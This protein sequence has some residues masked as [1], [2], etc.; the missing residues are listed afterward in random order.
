MFFFQMFQLC[1]TMCELSLKLQQE[2]SNN[3]KNWISPFLIMFKYNIPKPNVK[4]RVLSKWY[5]AKFVNFPG[6][7][8]NQ[9]PQIYFIFRVSIFK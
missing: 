8:K 4:D 9:V 7:F 6:G 2:F 1:F 5:T 3:K